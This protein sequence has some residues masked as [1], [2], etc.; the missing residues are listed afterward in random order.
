[1]WGKTSTKQSPYTGYKVVTYRNVYDGAGNL[2]SSTL[3]ARSNYQSR[4]EIILVGINGRPA[5][6]GST[7]DSTET[8]GSVDT[9]STGDSTE[10]GGSVDT[11]STGDSTETGGS[12]DTGD[13]GDST[14]SGDT[15]GETPDS[16][17]DEPIVPDVPVEDPQE[18]GENPQ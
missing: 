18:N 9:G 15:G 6:T 4:D 16:G 17:I 5:D 14:E 7:G 13:T 11:G 12:V 10:T 2:I 3:E 1:M 8:G